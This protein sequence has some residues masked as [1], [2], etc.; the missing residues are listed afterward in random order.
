MRTVIMIIASVC[1]ASSGCG[2]MAE[3]RMADGRILEGKIR[4]GDN[5]A[6]YIGES[7]VRVP[8]KDIVDIDHPGNGAAITGISLVAYGIL[9][10]LYVTSKLDNENEENLFIN[11]TWTSLVG[12]SPAIVGLGLAIWGGMVWLG[13]TGAAEERT[14]P[15][16]VAPL[17]VPSREGNIYGG[18]LTMRF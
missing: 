11:K 16:S 4:G 8:R 6:I 14:Q 2:T 18:T 1:I 5:D 15:V 9:N 13:S 10:G 3:V 12:F 17:L 7:R